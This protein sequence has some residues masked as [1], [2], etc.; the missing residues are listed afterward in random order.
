[1]ALPYIHYPSNPIAKPPCGMK[2]ARMFGFFLAGCEQKMQHFVD[3]TLNSI[4]SS[5]YFFK[6]LGSSPL[7]SFTDI[8]RIAS[9]QAPFSEYGW[10]Q[11]TDIIIWLPVVKQAKG[12]DRALHLYWFPAFICV[13]NI[14]ALINGRE[15]WG[16]N[17]YLCRYSM[18]E[19]KRAN[20][21]FSLQLETFQPYHP[22]TQMAWHEL[23]RV[24]RVDDNDNWLSEAYETTKEIAELLSQ[25]A[26]GAHLSKELIK[27]LL[28]G[29]THPY[30]D[31]ILFKQCPD[32]MAQ[33]SLYSAVLHSPS[34]INAI[35]EVGL[36]EGEYEV[37]IR[38]LD[39][40]PLQQLFGIAT[41][42]QWAR[43]PYYVNMD[44]EQ[45]GARVIVEQGYV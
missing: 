9:L 35:H 6:V 1:M 11:E 27:Q 25:G 7:L 12:D 44:F 41:G 14:N 28:G 32:G 20:S 2:D 15:I 31:Q 29:V 23:L 43:L 30:L 8:T 33:N 39:A 26:Q 34:T 16:Y 42:K 13:N 4:D 10:M 3:T 45:A 19:N 18:P 40:F 5:P 24:R 37:D 22:N 38:H 17:K 36:L 21:D